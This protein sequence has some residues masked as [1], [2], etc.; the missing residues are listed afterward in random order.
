MPSCPLSGSSVS[1]FCH[2]ERVSTPPCGSS[3]V[4]LFGPF[5]PKASGTEIPPRQF[6]WTVLFGSTFAFSGFTPFCL[7][8]VGVL[9]RVTT[10]R[11]PFRRPCLPSAV[12]P[13]Q[14]RNRSAGPSCTFTFLFL[15]T[16]VDSQPQYAPLP[17]FAAGNIEI[18]LDSHHRTV[19]ASG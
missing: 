13:C 6:F 18:R 3:V 8:S 19:S 5:S 15:S 2:C 10:S 1:L 17:L 9:V 7:R 12:I 14:S 16:F 4:D 11:P